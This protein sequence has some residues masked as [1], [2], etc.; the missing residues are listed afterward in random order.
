MFIYSTTVF[1]G[2]HLEDWA[3]CRLRHL[4]LS[5]HGS[6]EVLLTFL[7]TEDD[8]RLNWSAFC[9]SWFCFNC[10]VCFSFIWII[11][12]NIFKYNFSTGNL[13]GFCICCVFNLF[14]LFSLNFMCGYSLVFKCVFFHQ[15]FLIWFRNEFKGERAAFRS[16]GIC[17]LTIFFVHSSESDLIYQTVHYQ[18]FVAEGIFNRFC[19][20]KLLPSCELGRK[21]KNETKNM[22]KMVF[23]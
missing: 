19:I 23:D 12:W 1:R 7:P 9:I 8:L 18:H 13:I 10:N 22:I 20:Q 14:P 11:Y 21:Q 5:A 2:S 17:L 3:L 16:Y 6:M 15:I 4:C